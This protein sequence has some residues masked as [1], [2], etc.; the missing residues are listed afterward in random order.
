MK[1]QKAFKIFERK[2]ASGTT[3]YRVDLGEVNGKR[4]FKDF[5]NKEAAEAYRFKMDGIPTR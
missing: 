4:R 3:G 2:R 1:T 5:G